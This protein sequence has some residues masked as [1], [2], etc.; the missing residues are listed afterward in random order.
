MGARSAEAA[1]NSWIRRSLV[2]NAVAGLTLLG[3]IVLQVVMAQTYGAGPEVALFFLA[4]F[5]D[6]ELKEFSL[7]DDKECLIENASPALV[8]GS[9]YA[10]GLFHFIKLTWKH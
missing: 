3:K 1:G 9:F 4:L 7:I 10:C 8:A 6:L 5:A 2:L